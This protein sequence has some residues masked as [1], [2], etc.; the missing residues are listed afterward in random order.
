[1]FKLQNYHYKAF[2]ALGLLWA[3]FVTV[4]RTFRWP[5]DWA[6]AHWLT[7]YQFGFLKRGLAGTLIAPFVNSSFFGDSAELIIRIAATGFF[8]AFCGVLLFVC[9]RIIKRSHFGLD[10]LFLTLVFLTSPYIVLSAHLNGYY[11]NILLI[12]TVGACLLVM[13]GKVW[14]ATILMVLGV[15]IHELFFVVGF[16]SVVFCTLIKYA[17]NPL[18]ATGVRRFFGFWRQNSLL[19]F[20]PVIIFGWIIFN[21]TVILGAGLVKQQLVAHLS[22][23]GFVENNRNV[24][25]P[26]AFTTSFFVYLREEGPKFYSRVTNPF[27]FFSITMPLLVLLGFGWHVLRAVNFRKPIFVCL[28]AITLLPLSVHAMAWDTGR[29]WTFPIVIALLGIWVIMEIYPEVHAEQKNSLFFIICAL[30]ITGSQL[31]IYSRLVEGIPERFTLE[32][33]TFLYAPALLLIAW[34]V[35]KFYF[36][37]KRI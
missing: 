15:L 34:G 37:K 4:I 20:L 11:D 6:E 22:Q 31:L 32:F 27:W 28:S 10:A 36:L 33:R 14:Q 2:I 24:I 1:M 3:F 23:F 5:N 7:S 16:P 35:S 29:F 25:V 21:Q 26:K 8:L 9:F 30:I 12:I 18:G 13:V 19:V 17:K